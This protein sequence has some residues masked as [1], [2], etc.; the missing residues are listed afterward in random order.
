MKGM[1]L[2]MDL[3]CCSRYVCLETPIGLVVE[4]TVF[5]PAYVLVPSWINKLSKI[6]YTRIY[7]YERISTNE[8]SILTVSPLFPTKW[9]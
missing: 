5:R 6:N 7:P 8:H 2:K 4:L 9:V 1:I 3:K